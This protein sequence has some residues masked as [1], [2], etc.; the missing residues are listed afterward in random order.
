MDG[1]RV[2]EYVERLLA[3]IEGIHGELA[4]IRAELARLDRGE[5][6]PAD[7]TAAIA[8]IVV[9]AIAVLV[10]LAALAMAGRALRVVAGLRTARAAD[11]VPVAR[12]AFGREVRRYSEVLGVEAVT[13]RSASRR[14]GSVSRRSDLERRLSADREAGTLELL[15]EVASSRAGLADLP[16][17]ARIAANGLAAM[18][19]EWSIERWVADPER[20]MRDHGER[21]RLRRL[22]VGGRG[23]T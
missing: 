18:T 8:T 16:R 11:A 2:E 13:G 17:A 6:V 15:E 9:V 12:A 5:P 20:W 21:Q 19:T 4:G 14:D 1:D 23:H 3:A 10:A 22:G 7:P